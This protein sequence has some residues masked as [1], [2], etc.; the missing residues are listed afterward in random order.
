MNNSKTLSLEVSP[1]SHLHIV[2][3]EWHMMWYSFPV[4]YLWV[5]ALQIKNVEQV[6]SGDVVDVYRRSYFFHDPSLDGEK[7]RVPELASSGLHSL[8]EVPTFSDT[9]SGFGQ[10][11]KCPRPFPR[12][13]HLDLPWSAW[14]C[15]ELPRNCGGERFKGIHNWQRDNLP[16]P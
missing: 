5:G 6:S 2:D 7:E 13:D 14:S 16:L 3:A 4:P 1:F 15:F 11:R 9:S 8:C 12:F 10:R